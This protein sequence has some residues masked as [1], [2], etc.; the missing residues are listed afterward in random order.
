MKKQI[1]TV[2]LVKKEISDTNMRKLNV[3]EEELKGMLILNAYHEFKN[4][5]LKKTI[6]GAYE[7]SVNKCLILI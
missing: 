5:N 6:L 4:I 3:T 7:I 1:M 2:I